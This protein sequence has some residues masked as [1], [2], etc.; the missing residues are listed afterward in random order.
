M[1]KKDE[2]TARLKALGVELGREVNLSGSNEELALRIAELEDELSNEND[3]PGPDDASGGTVN[4]VSIGTSAI[5]DDKPLA[6]HDATGLVTIKV[7]ATLHIDALHE[8]LDERVVIA[9]AGA[10]VRVTQ[11]IAAALE[12]DS[13]ATIE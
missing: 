4:A 9:E 1:S 7:L 13:L 2:L 8:T 5:T 6:A 12:R 3:L 10:T 11:D